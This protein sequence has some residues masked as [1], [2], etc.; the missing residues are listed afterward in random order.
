MRFVAGS[1]LKRVTKAALISGPGIVAPIDMRLSAKPFS[2][3]EWNLYDVATPV[4]GDTYGFQV[5]YDDGRTC[6]VDA[7]VTGMWTTRPTGVQ[8]KGTDAGTSTTPTFVW[9]A[10]SSPPSLFWYHLNLRDDAS[11]GDLWWTSLVGSE[12]SVLYND[13]GTAYS[14]ALGSA[15]PYVWTIEAVDSN[16]NTSA[17]EVLFTTP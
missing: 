7:P 12:T 11:S 8:P 3:F 2:L 4:V 1:N 10:P 6:S 13:N 16:G 5:T 14:P 17:D 15:K 9:S